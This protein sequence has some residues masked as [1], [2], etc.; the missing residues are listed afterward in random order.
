ME[1]SAQQ[2][3]D[4]GYRPASNKHRISIRM[5]P[6]RIKFDEHGRCINEK[7]VTS[8]VG[9]YRRLKKLVNNQL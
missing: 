9:V 4:K 7:Q 3:F 8:S 1:L 2:L 5:L 6:G